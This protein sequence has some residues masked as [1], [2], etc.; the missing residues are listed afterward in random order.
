MVEKS[1]QDFEG[2]TTDENTAPG[3]DVAQMLADADPQERAIDELAEF[4]TSLDVTTGVQAELESLE[5][6]LDTDDTGSEPDTAR[7][8][9]PGRRRRGA[10]P[11]DSDAEV[12]TEE[13]ELDVAD[14]CLTATIV[15]LDKHA[16]LRRVARALKREHV[17]HGIKVEE[18]KQSVAR[19]RA[20]DILTDV[21]VAEG[22]PA[23]PSSDSF[24]DWE[25]ETAGRAGTI[26]EDGSI[27]LRDRRLI[28]VVKE[29]QLLGHLR[30]SHEGTTGR[31][32]HGRVI[33]PRR[34]VA[35]ALVPG[36]N[37]RTENLD[38]DVIAC[39]AEVEGGVTHEE[40]TQ[41]GRHRLK[42][43]ISKISRI[44]QDVDYVTGHIEF[45]GEVV[46]AGSVSAL[47]EVHATGTVSI[48]G[49]VE[50]GAVVEA[51]GSILVGGGV[52]GE[53][54]RLTAGDN[55]MGK[56]LQACSVRAGGD[57]EIGAYVFEASLRCGGRLKVGGMGEGSGRA[58]VGGLV[59]AGKGVETPSLGSP[60]NPRI[61]LILGI[62]PSSVDQSED[63]RKRLRKVDARRRKL[64]EFLG[65]ERFNASEIKATLQ[66]VQD[67]Q[68]RAKKVKVVHELT[69]LGETIKLGR[70]RLT[71]LTKTQQVSAR[72]ADL[73]VEGTVFP[74][75]ELRI[76]DQALKVTEETRARRYRLLE[77][78]GSLLLHDGD[79]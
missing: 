30:P 43:G 9:G 7:H 28:T 26:L 20:G 61:R 79:A 60:S 15:R 51:G 47:F 41:K 42:I 3:G 52:V 2:S 21:V 37:I 48:E 31:D 70:D 68:E 58:L 69:K 62:D 23:A 12:V 36:A 78:D 6:S 76:G 13:I 55:V 1:D 29:G 34:P 18:I 40:S 56:F 65:L 32:V 24:F 38:D 63:L 35:L 50:A 11:E 46:I 14:H 73:V 59:W 8:S 64:L 49:N 17:R 57:I 44:E 66:Q 72:T 77:E 54:T 4:L 16:S 75:A 33:T 39:Y 45:D 53:D 10:R 67:K 74:G 19:A 5:A 25:I 22:D 71:A 27:D